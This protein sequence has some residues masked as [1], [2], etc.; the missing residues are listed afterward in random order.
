MLNDFTSD[1][2]T[3]MAK[4]N[5]FILEVKRLRSIY[6]EI[7]KTANDLNALC[8]RELFIPRNSTYA[9]KG[10]QNL[11]V[12]RVNQTTHGL[13]SIRYQRPK[14]WN[15]L[16]A[17][18][19]KAS[20]FDKFKNLMKT[21]NGPLLNPGHKEINMIHDQTIKNFCISL[22]FVLLWSVL[23]RVHFCFL[24]RRSTSN[25]AHVLV[26]GYANP[27]QIRGVEAFVL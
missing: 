26:M 4:A 5:T 12:P 15:S 13:K 25:R 8:M 19:H 14:I 2:E 11:S 17:D 27:S 24:P 23:E 1:Y 6:T 3:L 20:F 22:V 16:P 18:F 10:P 7:Y 21:W 9:L